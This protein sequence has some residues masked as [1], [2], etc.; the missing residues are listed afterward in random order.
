M[1]RGPVPDEG[2]DRDRCADEDG[3][4]AMAEVSRVQAAPARSI[5]LEQSEVR[6][7]VSSI[8]G[9]TWGVPA[10]SYPLWVEGPKS[11]Y[12]A[13]SRSRTACLKP[14]SAARCWNA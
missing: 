2:R 5:P 12:G 11:S 3:A 14:A 4:G 7:C 8:S 6:G 1:E 10:I 9:E 13:A